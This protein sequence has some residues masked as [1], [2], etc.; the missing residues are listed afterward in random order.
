[1]HQ[2]SLPPQAGDSQVAIVSKAVLL[3]PIVL[4]G[5]PGYGYTGGSLL[6]GRIYFAGGSH[7]YSYAVPD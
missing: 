2:R 6:N 4:A 3:A 5:T 7:L 1:V